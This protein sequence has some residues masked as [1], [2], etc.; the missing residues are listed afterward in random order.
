MWDFN[1]VKIGPMGNPDV[2]FIYHGSK[3]RGK[4][5]GYM[6]LLKYIGGFFL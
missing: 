4:K 5:F 2:S 6:V 1:E 3:K